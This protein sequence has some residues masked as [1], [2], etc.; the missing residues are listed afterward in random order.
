MHD[1]GL[2]LDQ[3]FLDQQK[4]ELSHLED[5]VMH[6]QT[7]RLIQEHAD[8]TYMDENGEILVDMKP[9]REEYEPEEG[10]YRF[11]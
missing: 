1:A 6:D 5:I 4:N 10:E 7:E 2:E 9:L 8:Y 3:T 11:M